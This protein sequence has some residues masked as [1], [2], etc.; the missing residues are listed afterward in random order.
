[1]VNVI[2]T[3]AGEQKNETEAQIVGLVSKTN[4]VS[5]VCEFDARIKMVLHPVGWCLKVS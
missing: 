4:S 3:Q 2:N 1:M 5:V